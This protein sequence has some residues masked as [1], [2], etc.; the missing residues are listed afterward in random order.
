MSGSGS[1]QL[2]FQSLGARSTH[3]DQVVIQFIGVVADALCYGLPVLTTKHQAFHG[4]VFKLRVVG[5]LVH[6]VEHMLFQHLGIMAESFLGINAVMCGFPFYRLHNVEQGDGP[7]HGPADKAGS[8]QG[9]VC[10]NGEVGRHQNS[11]R[12]H[13]PMVLAEFCSPMEPPRWLFMFLAG[14]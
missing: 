8:L 12:A 10:L 4:E 2:R 6:P 13:D 3:Y 14:L 11:F 9:A 1:F 7:V 5:H